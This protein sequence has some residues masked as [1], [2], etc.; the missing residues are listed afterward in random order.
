MFSCLS[1]L[2]LYQRVTDFKDFHSIDPSQSIVL[3]VY[4]KK[5]HIKLGSNKQ[6]QQALRIS[7]NS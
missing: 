2:S 3:H 1:Q 6:Q 4:G 7:N 5:P